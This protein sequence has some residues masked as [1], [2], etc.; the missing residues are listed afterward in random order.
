MAD[1]RGRIINLPEEVSRKVSCVGVFN[2]HLDTIEIAS[3]HFTTAAYYNLTL[4]CDFYYEDDFGH[5]D[6]GKPYWSW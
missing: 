6:L 2:S 1:Y 3:G 5:D 4:D